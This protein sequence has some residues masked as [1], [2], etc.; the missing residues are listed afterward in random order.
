MEQNPYESPQA[1]Q[2]VTTG[3]VVKRGLGVGAI[4]LL[5]PV[6]VAIAFGGSCAATYAVLDRPWINKQNLETITSI[7]FAVFLVP[8]ATVLIAMIGWAIL[9]YRKNKRL[10]SHKTES[11]RH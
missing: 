11:Q 9:T 4:L 8:P 2:P 6:A 10:S 1:D 3:N 7:G 5:T